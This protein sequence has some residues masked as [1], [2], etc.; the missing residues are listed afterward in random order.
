M[1]NIDM[2]AFQKFT[3]LVEDQFTYGGKKYGLSGSEHREST[4]VL[5]DKHGKNWLIGTIDKYT[6][7]FANLARERDLLK[8]A[9]YMYIMWL[10]RGFHIRLD[11]I[12]DPPLDTNIKQKQDNFGIFVERA[13]QYHV[14]YKESMSDAL[15]KLI[16]SDYL[17]AISER[18]GVLSNLKWVEMQE[19]DLLFIYNNSFLTWVDRYA[20]IDTHDT[21]T[22]STAKK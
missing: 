22:Y 14:Q 16:H 19:S 4:D 7:R 9:C 8:I 5:F 15:T 10:K 13:R 2:N 18:L 11:G 12:N 20:N 6:F 21:D 17:G 1:D 3:A